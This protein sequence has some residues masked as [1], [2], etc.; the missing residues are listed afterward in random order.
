[1]SLTYLDHNAT[2]PVKPAIRDLMLEMLT[3]PG[4]ASAIHKQGREARRRLED[5]RTTIAQK[6]NAGPRDIIV[7]TS[8]AT[9]ANNMLFNGID[10]EQV[11]TSTIEHPSVMQTTPAARHIPVTASGMVDLAALDA[12]LEGNTKQTLISVMAV[13][14]ETGV[15]QPLTEIVAIA[16]KYGAL[17]H[18]DAV[19]AIGRIPFDIQTLGVDFVTLSGHKIGAPQGVGCL[20]IANCN[21]VAPLLR[22]G[23]QEKNLRA[24]TENLASICAFAKAID[25][26]DGAQ[27]E[28]HAAW[29]DKLETA[30]AAAAPMLRFFGKDAPRVSNTSMFAL[31]GAPSEMQLITLDLAGICVSNGSACSS[32]TVKASHVLKAMGASDAEAM[33][34]LRVSFG[35]NTTEKEVDFFIEQWLKMFDRIKNRLDK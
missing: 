22:G 23:N 21:V 20:I 13:N 15:I 9:E 31:P 4:N 29:R 14:N 7:F 10:V 1:M 33:A 17:V 27:N 5:A 19:Q 28:Q 2:T 34:S 16:R 26:A 24:G 3:F 35:W 6:L 30:L 11:L 25:L 8:G 18:T 32:G 12:M